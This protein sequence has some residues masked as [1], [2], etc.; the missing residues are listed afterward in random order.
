MD[1]LVTALGERLAGL[2][3]LGPFLLRALPAL[4][5]A[6]ALPFALRNT[7]PLRF[8]RD[9]LDWLLGI[10]LAVLLLTMVLL[11]GLQ[12]LL[13]NA[14]DSGLL[15]IDPLLRHLVLLLAFTGAVAATGTKRHVQI[16][17]LGRLLR[18]AG[19]RIGGTAIALVAAGGSLALAHAGLELL[20]EELDFSEVVF[21]GIESWIVVGVFPLA[22]LVLA[23]RFAWLMFAEITGEAPASVEAELE[24]PV[25]SDA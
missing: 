21:L 7:P 22:F 8:L 24:M 3:S 4:L 19:Q 6:V 11:S 9:R 5:L 14:F 23:F 16:N 25:R 17:V 1:A 10:L 2:P 12:I 18:G 13:R 15:W 20:R